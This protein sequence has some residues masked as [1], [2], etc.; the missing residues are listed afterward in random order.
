MCFSRLVIEGSQVLTTAQPDRCWILRKGCLHT[1]SLSYRRR[2]LKSEVPWHS[3]LTTCL[4]EHFGPEWFQLNECGPSPQC[5]INYKGNWIFNLQTV[6]SRLNRPKGKLCCV[7]ADKIGRKKNRNLA[8]K[9]HIL[10]QLLKHFFN[11]II[12]FMD[13]TFSLIKMASE[14]QILNILLSACIV[15]VF[16]QN[17]R[18][19]VW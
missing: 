11:Y 4:P 13:S 2:T 10:S 18:F 5:G 15:V 16:W 12:N 8:L 3:G 1:F 6:A 9:T 14:E 17:G 19:G 7:T